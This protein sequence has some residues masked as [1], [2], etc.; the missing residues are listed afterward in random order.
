MAKRV[1]KRPKPC[2]NPVGARKDCR[3]LLGGE[4]RPKGC[5]YPKEW[6]AEHGVSRVVVD[7]LG[8]QTWACARLPCLSPI[9]ETAMFV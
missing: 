8:R 3:D 6:E 9:P 5:G 4:S 1:G 2:G 7:A